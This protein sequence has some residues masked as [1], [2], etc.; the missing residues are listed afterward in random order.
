MTFDNQFD[1]IEG[2]DAEGKHI[3]IP[4]EDGPFVL[5]FEELPEDDGP[6]KFSMKIGNV[7]S[8]S[9]SVKGTAAEM[10]APLM[11]TM[12]MPPP[13]IFE[14]EQAVSLVLEGVKTIEF[15]VGERLKLSG[16]KG[17][18]IFKHVK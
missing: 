17:S 9:L 11:S 5:R 15:V 3:D 1:L 16:T 14:L 12:M 7:K 10:K 13:A 18:L 2:K 8:G 4:S 6:Y